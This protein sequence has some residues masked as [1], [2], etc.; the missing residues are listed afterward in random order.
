MIQI[1]ETAPR[2]KTSVLFCLWF[3]AYYEKY[4]FIVSMFLLSL[5]S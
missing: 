3:Q 1:N 4:F 5:Y 2:L